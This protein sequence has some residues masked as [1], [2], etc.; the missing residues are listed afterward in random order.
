MFLIMKYLI[1]NIAM[2]DTHPVTLPVPE[3]V[4]K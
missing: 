4:L 3:S 1:I 2:P